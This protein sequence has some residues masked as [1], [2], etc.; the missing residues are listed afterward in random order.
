[1]SLNIKD[2]QTHLLARELARETGETMTQAVN[3]A[4]KE[5]LL[6]LQRKRNSEALVA[7]LLTIGRRYAKDLK[8]GVPIGHAELLYNDRGLPR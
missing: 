3:E 8:K 6:R 1:M 2:P 7:D 4:L 5:R